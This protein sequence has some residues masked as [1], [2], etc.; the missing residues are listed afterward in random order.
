[1][2]LEDLLQWCAS[3]SKTGTLHLTR[4]PIEKRLFFKKGRLFS[5]TSTN[6]RET[7]GQFLIRSGKITEEQLFDALI[8]Q[9]R[10][11][12]PLGQILVR[13]GLLQQE[14][15]N[16]MLRIKTEE[17][18]YDTFLWPDGDFRFEEHQLPDKISVYLPL[19]LTALI[20][21]G[22]RRTDEWKRIWQVFPSRST[23][24]ATLKNDTANISEEDRRILD[25]VSR[26]K[27]LGEIALELHAVDFYAASRLLELLERGLIKVDA[28]KEEIPF[29]QQIEDLREKLRE[30]VA[31]FN[32]AQYPEALSTFD[33]VLTIDPQNKYARLFK[34]KIERLMDELKDTVELPLDAVPVS[35]CTLAELADLDL[36]AQEGF[37][38]SRVN[39][40]W[41]IRSILKICPMRRVEVM[42]IFK[43]LLDNELIELR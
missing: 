24:F 5:S 9:D 8:R 21:E 15:L 33:T 25:L 19:E 18:I 40:E 39:G 14:E 27:N 26:R 35:K 20:L 3:N 29:E 1:M 34:V 36:D 23:T 13:D 43:R 10:Q 32:G 17:S 42:A 41:D 4:G 30:G 37:V 2:H 31:Y 22:A 38:L 11:H 6:P 28:A 7:L 12:E 16:E